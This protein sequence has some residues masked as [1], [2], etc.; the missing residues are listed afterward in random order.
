MEGCYLQ[1]GWRSSSGLDL[2]F[3]CFASSRKQDFA[4]R[5]KSSSAIDREMSNNKETP[6]EVEMPWRVGSYRVAIELRP[7]SVIPML[8]FLSET[9]IRGTRREHF[10]YGPRDESWYL[11]GDDRE[12][13]SICHSSASRPLRNKNSGGTRRELFSYRPRESSTET[14]SGLVAIE[15]RPRSAIPL[16]R[17]F[18]ETR[19][20]AT[21]RELLSCTPSACRCHRGVGC[22]RAGRD[23]TPAL[24]EAVAGEATVQRSP[25]RATGA[26]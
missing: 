10:S 13:A 15:H 21:S 11:R 22:Y 5:D 3:L 20:R 19:T 1:G 14:P 16:L 25:A 12:T 2:P 6:P 8:R 24:V 9:R 4:R 17:F 7:R 23:G 26:A 18:L